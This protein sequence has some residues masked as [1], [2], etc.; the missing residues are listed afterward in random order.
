MVY[1]EL[2]MYNFPELN[3]KFIA[4]AEE[5]K[6]NVDHIIENDNKEQVCSEDS[7]DNESIDWS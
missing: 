5:G 7:K 6:S 3:D 4:N 1:E 2:V